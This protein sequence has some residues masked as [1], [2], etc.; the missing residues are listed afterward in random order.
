M[1]STHGRNDPSSSASSIPLCWKREFN[2]HSPHGRDVLTFGMDLL[3]VM[4][5]ESTWIR[6]VTDGS[7]PRKSHRWNP[8]NQDMSQILAP[9]SEVS[10][11]HGLLKYSPPQAAEPSLQVI[12]DWKN[13][14]DKLLS[15]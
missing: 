15:Q 2:I 8:M 9:W 13:M 12:L 10:G 7:N 3:G 6:E 1:R 11:I 4:E 5:L 14:L